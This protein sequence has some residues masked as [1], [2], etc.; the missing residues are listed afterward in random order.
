M[1]TPTHPAIV[2]ALKK[3]GAVILAELTPSDCDMLHMAIGVSGE[4][5][6]LLECFQNANFHSLDSEAMSNLVEE[7][8]DLEFYLEGFRQ[9]AGIDRAVILQW[10]MEN[11]DDAA[12]MASTS[13]PVLA[14][15][16]S[17]LN[18]WAGKFLDQVKR[19]AIYRKDVLPSAILSP[20][21]A[22]ETIMRRIRLTT[23]VTR[24][25]V[26][27]ANHAKLSVRYKGLFYSDKAAQERADKVETSSTVS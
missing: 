27:E 19:S 12:R 1:N 23:G 18:V 10:A 20:L 17:A 13:A 4:A 22:I 5:A 3:S 9:V 25:V 16:G 11:G 14:Q 6:E 26:L 24:E 21:A 7:L 2:R 8:G 15:L